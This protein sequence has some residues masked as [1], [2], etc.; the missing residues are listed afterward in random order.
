MLTPHQLRAA[1]QVARWIDQNGNSVDDVR[2]AYSTT[3]TDEAF[4]RES[5]IDGE[6]VLVSAGLVE[7][8]GDH[9]LPTPMLSEF[10]RATE[11]TTGERLLQNLIEAR[12]LADLRAA[13]GA[14]GEEHVLSEL[15]REFMELHRPDL[16]KAC[17]R[18]SLV[19]DAF[20]YDISAPTLRGDSRHLEVKT[21]TCAKPPATVRFFLTRN[22]YDTGRAQSAQW[23]LVLCTKP[24]HDGDPQIVG[25]CRAATLASYLPADSG[26]RWTEALV[27][28]PA[29]V[30]RAGLP[31]VI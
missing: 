7:R 18:V 22:E 11:D 4:R 16:A 12:D 8:R 24:L 10:V 1:I 28:L 25:W 21:Q 5:L 9:L 2:S 31:L 3:A 17:K 19:S 26:G 13:S 30:L 14:A 20:G 23:A 6:Q 15:R 27:R 29:S